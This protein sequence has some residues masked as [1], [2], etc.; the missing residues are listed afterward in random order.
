MSKAI[1]PS[2]DSEVGTSAKPVKKTSGK[3]VYQP[4]SEE[5]SHFIKSKVARIHQNNDNG[6][7]QLSSSA[8]SS[9]EDD[10]EPEKDKV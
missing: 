8:D 1:Q 5:L 2:S 6:K 4:P 10:S 9:D 3:R 7:T